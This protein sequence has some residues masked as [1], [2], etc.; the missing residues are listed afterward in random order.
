MN[1]ERCVKSTGIL[2]L[3]AAVY[4]LMTLWTPTALDDWIFMAEWRDVNHNENPNFRTIFLFWQD[5]RLYDN[6]RLSN[7][8]VP[9][10]TYFAFGRAIFPILNGL[11]VAVIVWLVASMAFKKVSVAQLTVA[12]AFIVWMLPW[13]NSIFVCDYSLN[14]IWASVITMVF[15]RSV[16]TSEERGWNAVRFTLILLLAFIAGGWH[17]GFA[18]TTIAGFLLYTLVRGGRFS[19]EWWIIGIFYAAVT[20]LF[21]LCPG[22]LARTQEEMGAS[23]MHLLRTMVDFFPLWLMIVS[24]ALLAYLPGY[25]KELKEIIGTPIFIIGIGVAVSGF[26]LALLFS[27]QPRSAFWPNLMCVIMLLMLYRPLLCRIWQG[28]SGWLL[29]AGA[30]MLALAPMTVS[31][32]WQY[33]FYKESEEILSEMEKRETGTVFRDLI[34]QEDVPL[35]ALKMPS[36]TVWQTPYNFHALKQYVLKPFPAVV[37]K[38]FETQNWWENAEK[39]EGNAGLYS[40]GTSLALINADDG[41]PRVETVTVELKDGGEFQ[42]SALIIPFITPAGVQGE[43]LRLYHVDAT[44]VK[45]VYFAE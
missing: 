27:H 23:G 2:L 26:L 42:T 5:I 38:E 36:Y 17:E 4:F 29:G 18:I 1:I 35:I 3:I 43:Y 40:T 34:P 24:L 22:M 20:I 7:T 6:A 25:K 21:Y 14:Y 33:R 32:V 37:P 28:R 39:L 31:L 13:R 30:V 10:F 19:V 16:L 44:E 11:F 45:A 8:I 15:I 41:E 12:W 9:L